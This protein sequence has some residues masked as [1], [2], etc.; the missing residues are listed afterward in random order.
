M[1]IQWALIYLFKGSML[2]FM[3]LLATVSATPRWR[4]LIVSAL[5]MWSLASGDC[6]YLPPPFDKRERN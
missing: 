5:Y 2:V 1:K 6:I 3:T 4:V